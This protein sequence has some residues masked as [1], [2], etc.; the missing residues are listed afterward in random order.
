MGMSAENL[1][2][3]YKISQEQ[4][5]EYSVLSQKRFAAAQEAGRLKAEISPGEIKSREGPALFERDEHNPP[6]T[7]PEGLRKLPQLL[8]KDGVGHTRAAS[9]VCDRR[10]SLVGAE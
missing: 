7:T 9:G 4:V 5:D 10:R 3:Q 2:A 8:K 1:A 6:D